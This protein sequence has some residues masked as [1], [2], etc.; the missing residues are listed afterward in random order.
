MGEEKAL[1]FLDEKSFY[2]TRRRKRLKHL[3]QGPHES[4][5]IGRVKCPR[6]L[7]CH[8]PIKVIFMGVVAKPLPGLRFDRII[9]LKRISER[10]V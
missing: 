1:V 4:E 10:K 7:S 2:T 8:F 6:A 9:F 3:P 5:G